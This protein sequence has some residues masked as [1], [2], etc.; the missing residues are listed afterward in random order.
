MI[1]P[2]DPRPELVPAL[3]AAEVGR[4]LG[5]TAAMVKAIPPADL[6]YFRNG[7]D[8]AHRRYQRADVETYIARRRVG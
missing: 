5:L 2:K 4:V 1:E 8:R 6:P 7:G 3:T